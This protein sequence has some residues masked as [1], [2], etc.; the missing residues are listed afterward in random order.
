M[1]SGFIKGPY[2]GTTAIFWLF[3]TKLRLFIPEEGDI[4]ATAANTAHTIRRLIQ[5]PAF[6]TIHSQEGPG[7]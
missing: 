3:R 4:R 2:A 7:L 5:N 6:F 1:K